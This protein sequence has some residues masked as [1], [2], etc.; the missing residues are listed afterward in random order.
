MNQNEVKIKID[1]IECVAQEGEYI[2]NVARANDIFIPAICYIS[3]CSPTLACRLCLV[4][5]DGK[6]A[7]ACNAKAKEGMEVIT[8][9]EEI[10]EER[11]AIMEVYDINHPLQC[12]VCDQSGECELQNYTLELG[13]DSQNYSISDCKR[14]SA[15]WSSVLHYDP[16]LCIVCERCVTVCKDMVGDNAL[17]TT[18]RGGAELDKELKESM[19]KDAYAMWNKLQKSLIAP[20]DESG[21][22]N[23]SDCGEC[24][25]VCPVGAL[26]SRDFVYSSNAWELKR[27][28]A[29]CSH[30][31][32]G[33]Q[34]FYE[35]KPTSISD[36]S[37]KIYRVT[38]E[39]N[40]V[41]L[42]GA[43][44]FGYDFENVNVA[45]DE[46]QF[47][48][49]IE[50]FKK[51]KAIRFNSTITNEEALML[52]T[53]KKELG[54]K[55]INPEAKAFQDFLKDFESFRGESLYGG[56]YKEMMS[57]SNFIISVGSALRHDNP[58]VRYVFNNIQKLNKGAGLYFHPVGDTLIEGLGK[59]VTPLYHDA[60][61][62]E[63]ALYLILDLFASKEELPK[64]TREYLENFHKKSTKMVKET[65][66]EDVTET[67]VD[68]ETGESKEIT[69]KK[70]KV[71]EKE[72]ECIQNEL[73]L[74]LNAPE[75]FE[76]IFAKM[77]A[78]ADNFSMIV[79]EDL[80][81]HPR[82]ENLTKLLALIEKHTQIKIALIPPKTNSLGVALI[83]D[84]DAKTDGYTIGYNEKGDFRL[85]ALGEGDL[86]MPALNQQ[87]GTFTNMHKRVVPTNAALSYGGYELNDIMNA[88]GLGEHLS[89][90]WTSKL[91]TRKGFET[92]SFDALPNGF[93]NAGEELRGYLLKQ[94]TTK[95]KTF[96][97]EKPDDT[98]KLEGEIAY[99][100]NP[101]RQF[102]DFTNK[103]HQIFE[104][105]ALYVSE[106]K[107][108][109]LGKKAKVE[110]GEVSLEL[111]VMIDAK[112]SGNIVKV[113]DFLSSKEI[114]PLFKSG[115]FQQVKISEV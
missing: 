5:A 108:Q 72:V 64:E 56:D 65:I 34:I 100:C 51:A 85:S 28:P 103:A 102:S 19:P 69:K 58:N 55:L 16:G 88:L 43:G 46:K 78:K 63:Y 18:Q 107:A 20:N 87:E 47:V 38:N 13:I 113:P 86:D 14:E 82:A 24:L 40:Y 42:C 59:N 7:Y 93:T 73:A 111:P 22:T 84:L 75:D 61:L 26:V 35:T 23:C 37:E 17:G 112:M 53:L 39:W 95:V 106:E 76:D 29:T 74:L 1:G 99:R 105:F 57:E 8:T 21:Q 81:W 96:E 101:Q 6:R 66:M 60:G 54:V 30:C 41:S 109:S 77:T 52:Q 15:N 9:N 45:K 104:S 12:G 98:C 94:K 2:L 27:V 79:G 33:C 3:R 32:S 4:E 10:L 114:Y 11:R 90:D 89:V 44:R 48:K 83:C 68:E 31:S 71:V 36:R 67:V 70:P 91:P 115:R 62:E 110:I 49:A 92:L 80:Y 97:A 50:A 25:S